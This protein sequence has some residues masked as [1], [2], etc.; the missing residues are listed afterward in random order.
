MQTII[1]PLLQY[2]SKDVCTLV[3]SDDVNAGTK[4]QKEERKIT[5]IIHS[6]P[7]DCNLQKIQ[8]GNPPALIEDIIHLSQIW[9]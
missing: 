1:I 4:G 7:Q 2:A 6:Q 3:L 8:T 5:P 9:D